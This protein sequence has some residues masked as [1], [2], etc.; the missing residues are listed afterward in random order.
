[1][2]PLRPLGEML[3]AGATGGIELLASGF[4]AWPSFGSESAVRV[5]MPSLKDVLSLSRL[6]SWRFF[7]QVA[8]MATRVRAE[9]YGFSY[10]VIIPPASSLRLLPVR[11]L[12]I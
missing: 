4:S 6:R 1:M 5:V 2:G 12:R 10:P 3:K 7:S 9:M 8:R 11:S